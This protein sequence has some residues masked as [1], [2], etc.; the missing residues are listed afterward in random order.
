MK[1]KPLPFLKT[2]VANIAQNPDLGLVFLYSEP[3]KTNGLT[4]VSHESF[5]NDQLQIAKHMIQHFAEIT[6]DDLKTEFPKPWVE[7]PEWKPARLTDWDI[8]KIESDIVKI[9]AMMQSIE[10]LTIDKT[11][12]EFKLFWELA[13][14][15][16]ECKRI[17]K[18]IIRQIDEFVLFANRRILGVQVCCNIINLPK[19]SEEFE[20]ALHSGGLELANDIIKAF[21]FDEK[22]DILDAGLFGYGGIKNEDSAPREVAPEF[23]KLLRSLLLHESIRHG[24]RQ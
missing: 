7:I 10:R 16:G 11:D 4:S 13:R 20:S 12:P 24:Y 14:Q 15:D 19:D 2:H 5:T 1:I 3:E 9:K 22:M 18:K 23:V 8:K 21:S 17:C 6:R